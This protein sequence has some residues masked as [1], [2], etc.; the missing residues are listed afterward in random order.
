MYMTTDQAIQYI[1]RDSQYAELVYNAYLGKDLHSAAERFLY[2]PEFSEVQE[3]IGDLR[4]TT[5]LDLGAGTGIASYAFMKRDAK[6]V[7]A[8]EPDR[9]DIIGYGAIKRLTVGMPVEI[10]DAYGEAIPLPD[11]TVD[12]VYARQV[13][14]HTS[15]LNQVLRECARVLKKGGV[16]IAC[17]EHVVDN[18]KQLEIF[19]RNHP[20]HQ[21]AGGENAFPLNMYLDGLSAAGLILR[22]EFAP[23]DSIINAFPNVKTKEELLHYPRT[24]LKWRLGQFGNSIGDFPIAQNLV[25]KWLNRSKP[26]RLYSFVAVKSSATGRDQC[27]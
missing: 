6:L 13:L 20:I 11:E 23:W 4:G 25:L 2:S 15:K 14:H 27:N 19:L 16:F 9:S 3:V 7:Y 18:K 24:W 5:V 10:I 26:G 8:L 21:L 12:V 22:Y 1:R 17:R